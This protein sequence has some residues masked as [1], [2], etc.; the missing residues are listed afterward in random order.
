MKRFIKISII[1]IVLLLLESFRLTAPVSNNSDRYTKIALN[2]MEQIR[3]EGELEL[4][5]NQIDYDESRNNW[6]EVNIIGAFGAP[7]FMYKT[8]KGLGYGHITLKK[9]KKD[10]SIFPPE[11]Q[12]KVL[13]SL[14]ASNTAIMSEY[15]KKYEGFEIIN[16]SSYSLDPIRDSNIEIIKVTKSGILAACHLGGPKSVKLYLDSGGKINKKD[17]F[18]TSIEDYMK[19]YSNF[20]LN[21]KTY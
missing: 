14:I 11:L 21:L 3:Y 13:K 16:I 2:L 8:L 17:L 7:Q 19:R 1:I 12:R 10:P 5:C 20:N 18:K 15:I 9:F 6:L 4:F